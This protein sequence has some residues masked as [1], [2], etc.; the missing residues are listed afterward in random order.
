MDEGADVSQ[1]EV[2]QLQRGMHL[3]NSEELA[4]N[5]IEQIAN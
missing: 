5:R 3:A 1:V 2:Y 4:K